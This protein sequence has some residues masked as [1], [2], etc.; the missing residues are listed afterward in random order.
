L[1]ELPEG[2]DEIIMEIPSLLKK[3]S[4]EYS[5]QVFFDELPE[6]ENLGMVNGNYDLLLSALK[7]I[8]ENGCK[9]SPDHTV[10]ISLSFVE[11]RI[12]VLFTN[13][14]ESFNETEIDTIFQPFQRGTNATNAPG[15]GLGL[16]LTRRIILLHKGEIKAEV[17][18]KNQLLV[19]V[20][21]PSRIE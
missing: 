6:N 5:A 3:V 4:S 20:I 21:F 13:K 10:N 19:S 17:N 1:P 8:T 12:L 18:K 14:T 16:S 15:Y 11:R 2:I 9:Y 7:N